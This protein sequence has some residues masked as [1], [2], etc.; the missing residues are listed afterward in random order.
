[1][2]AVREHPDQVGYLEGEFFVEHSAHASNAFRRHDLCMARCRPQ[3]EQHAPLDAS[4]QQAVAR[5]DLSLDR[6]G[7]LHAHVA[8]KIARWNQRSQRTLPSCCCRHRQAVC[9]AGDS[10]TVN[11]ALIRLSDEDLERV[12]Q[13]RPII[14]R[15]LAHSSCLVIEQGANCP[16]HDTTAHGSQSEAVLFR[17]HFYSMRSQPPVPP[18]RRAGVAGAAR[19]KATRLRLRS[20]TIQPGREALVGRCRLGGSN[21]VDAIQD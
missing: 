2:R 15:G 17:A 6:T 12:R 7:H 8:L 5:R 1:M 20:D 13:A 4:R 3:P 14:D 9:V 19:G 10:A 21:S 11:A 18:E 16:G